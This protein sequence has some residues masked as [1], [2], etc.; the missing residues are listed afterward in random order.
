MYIRRFKGSSRQFYLRRFCVIDDRQA[1]VLELDSIDSVEAAPHEVLLSIVFK[2]GRVDGIGYADLIAP[3]HLAQI[4]ERTAGGIGYGNAYSTG[5][6]ASPG[7]HGIV[8]YIFSV[9]VIDVR[10]PHITGRFEPWPCGISERSCDIMPAG[11]VAG[12]HDRH[13]VGVFRSI[14]IEVSVFASYDGGVGQTACYNGVLI[15][16]LFRWSRYII[17]ERRGTG[18]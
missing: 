13:V 10:S 6:N 12:G 1:V 2:V 14:Y 18:E 17:V 8:H 3:E 9:N 11:K 15:G 5:L 7:R 16:S 4:G